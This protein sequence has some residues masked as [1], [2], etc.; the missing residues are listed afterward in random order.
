[1]QYAW[2]VGN[3]RVLESTNRF[4]DGSGTNDPVP[5]AGVTLFEAALG[6]LV[7]TLFAAATLNV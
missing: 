1:M 7:P 6:G 3:L 5:T 2:L 4:G